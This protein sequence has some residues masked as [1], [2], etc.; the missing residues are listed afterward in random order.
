MQHQVISS[1][2]LI[3]TVAGG[4]PVGLALVLL[5]A[6]RLK[7]KHLFYASSAC[8]AAAIV[9]S[10]VVSIGGTCTFLETLLLEKYCSYAPFVKPSTIGGVISMGA[11]CLIL[12]V[13]AVV[14]DIFTKNTSENGRSN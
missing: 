12:F 6:V 2:L 14:R 5:P 11:L 13:V 7:A 3:I 4:I 8:L 9:F 1:W 10:G